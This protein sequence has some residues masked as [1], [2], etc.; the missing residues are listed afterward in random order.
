MQDCVPPDSCRYFPDPQSE[1]TVVFRQT[2]HPARQE[3]Q[4]PLLSRSY[5]GLHS[6]QAVSLLQTAQLLGQLAQV[7]P[8]DTLYMFDAAQVS[9]AVALEQA[10]HPV[11]HAEQVR[12]VESKYVPVTH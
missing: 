11:P 1:H 2:V 7:F 10:L 4:S 9:Q 6:L 8:P 3:T 5:P 12:A